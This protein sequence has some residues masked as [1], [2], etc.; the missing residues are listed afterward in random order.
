[1]H[2]P[3]ESSEGISQLSQDRVQ[4]PA[5]SYILQGS[6]P[7]VPI[8]LSS[9]SCTSVPL[10]SNTEPTRRKD[11]VDQGQPLTALER[12]SHWILDRLRGSGL[13]E[14]RHRAFLDGVLLD[15]DEWFVYV[16]RYWPQDGAGGTLR[17]NS[18]SS[19]SCSL[20][21]S[22]QV[23]VQMYST[24]GQ[25]NPTAAISTPSSVYP[26]TSHRSAFFGLK[27]ATDLTISRSA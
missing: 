7:S 19:Q 27:H 16:E 12:I 11:A 26:T 22:S 24:S 14:L 20:Q 8:W 6:V 3:A 25:Q 2:T 13:E 23:D 9:P 17:P 18:A 5:F 15:D 1:M 21:H 10:Q 4:P